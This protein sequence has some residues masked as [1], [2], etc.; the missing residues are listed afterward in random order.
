[1]SLLYLFIYFLHK[2]KSGAQDLHNGEFSSSLFLLSSS[3]IL[4]CSSL[5][6]LLIISLSFCL[7]L[8]Q[9]SS[10]DQSKCT[11]DESGA[12]VGQHF[13]TALD[14]WLCAGGLGT[15]GTFKVLGGLN[16]TNQ[17]ALVVIDVFVAHVEAAVT[18]PVGLDQ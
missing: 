16:G 2:S 8:S 17:F 12:G 11:R 1:M 14:G 9:S 4:H 10:E 5:M 15:A 3:A 13:A 18:R 7:V 6:I